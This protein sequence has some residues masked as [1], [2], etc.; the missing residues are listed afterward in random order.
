[1]SINHWKLLGQLKNSLSK[2][3]NDKFFQNVFGKDTFHMINKI[4]VVFSNEFLKYFEQYNQG[5]KF[6]KNDAK[7]QQ[8]LP[9]VL[10][11]A[12]TKLKTKDG[13]KEIKPK[14]KIKRSVSKCSILSQTQHVILSIETAENEITLLGRIEALIVHLKQF[15]EARNIAIRAGAIRTLLKVRRKTDGVCDIQAAIREGLAL[16]GYSDP[17]TGNGIR[18]L[19]MDGGGIRGLLVLEMLKK[20][21]EL[22]GKRVHELFDLFC[23]VSTGAILS[24]SL[25]IHHTDLNQVA[26]GYKDIS[27]EVFKQSPLWGTG[28]LVWSQAYYD[29]SLWEKKLQEHLGTNSLISTSRNS[30]CP[31]L[32]AISAV[33]N[34]SRLSA[35]VFRNYSLPWRVRPYYSGSS[36]YEVW[37]AARASAAAPTYFEEFKLGKFLHQDG[38][39]LVNNPTAVA[40]HEAKLI[41]PNTPIQCVVSF[42]TGRSVPTPTDIYKS[43][44]KSSSSTSWTDKFYKILDSATDTEG[45]ESCYITVNNFHVRY[46]LYLYQN[47]FVF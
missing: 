6:N 7:S 42:G 32:C 1:M 41:W 36:E 10:Q 20:L 4:P 3:T 29:T 12:K 39:I 15:P 43:T 44:P 9:T 26:E 25:G 24:F 47:F 38:G 17:V 37:Q 13:I 46:L 27:R 34:Q 11:D 33:V 2:I 19:A 35:Y 40:L 8:N 16:L 14:W 18:I 30:N 31:K 5:T 23:G 28:N 21:E 45:S 22:T